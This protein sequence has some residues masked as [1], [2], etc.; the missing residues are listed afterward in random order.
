MFIIVMCYMNDE[1]T[2]IFDYILQD[3]NPNVNDVRTN[4]NSLL[5]KKV[6]VSYDR[7]RK[8]FHIKERLAAARTKEAVVALELAA[9]EC[10]SGT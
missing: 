1:I 2:S 7:I 3:G 8:K 9:G 4:L 5:F 10:G 6:V